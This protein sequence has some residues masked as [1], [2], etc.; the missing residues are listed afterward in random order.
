M[1]HYIPLTWLTFGLDYVQWGMNPT[2][3]HLT[4]LLLYAANAA[5]LYLVSLRLLARA[6][7]LAGLPL[8]LG[9]V[10]A[11]LFFALHP[12]RAES[13]AWVTER[14]DVLSGLFFL[15]TILAY[16]RMRDAS[17]PRRYWL[18]AASAG[19]YVLALA[20]K[21]SVMV[22]P[23]MLLLLDIYPLR[24]LSRR[25]LVE[26]I[27]FVVLGIAGAAAAYWAQNANAFITPLQRYPLTARI[28]MTCY[29]LWFYLSKTVLPTGLGPLYELPARGRGQEASTGHRGRPRRDGRGVAHRPRGSHV[30]PG[31][32]L[33]RHGDALEVR[34]RRRARLRHLSQQS[35]DLS[36]QP[37]IDRSRAAAFPTGAGGPT[38]SGEDPLPSRLRRSGVGE[39]RQGGRGVCDFPQAVPGRRGRAEQLFGGADDPPPAR[40]GPRPDPARPQAQAQARLRQHESRLRARR[41]RRPRGGAE[42]VSSHAR[43]EV[44]HPPGVVRAG[45]GLSR[46]RPA[47]RRAHRAR[48]PRDDQPPNGVANRA[49]AA[50]DVVR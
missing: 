25:T 35:R 47:R 24:Q 50:H 40:R 38:G 6:T 32:D 46:N 13:V 11:T 2:G 18:L 44:R 33:A 20:S 28:G 17:G 1:G 42:A 16:L 14:R 41:T 3:Y 30:Q 8:R 49:R 15:L 26:K 48:D 21:G 43:A 23:A 19:A 12:L 39:L 4:S 10:A 29:S 9:A 5:V 37:R 34:G 22:L 27:P 31:P 45:Q 7:T 36:R